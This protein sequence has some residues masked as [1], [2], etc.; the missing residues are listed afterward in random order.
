MSLV[1]T[2]DSD[3]MLMR[4]FNVMSLF[5]NEIIRKNMFV[6]VTVN[7][8]GGIVVAY[9]KISLNIFYCQT[10]STN[11]LDHKF[12]QHWFKQYLLF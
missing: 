11:G 4:F 9:K 5:R 3:D 10:I 12:C 7:D 2:E 8:T 1:I 6:C